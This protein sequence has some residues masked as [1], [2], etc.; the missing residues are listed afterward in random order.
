MY[1]LELKKGLQYLYIIHIVNCK[2]VLYIIYIY[3]TC[4]HLHVHCISVISV[5]VVFLLAYFFLFWQF[6]FALF[7]LQT[8]LR[9]AHTRGVTWFGS[10]G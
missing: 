4:T 3:S 7:I 5:L 8:L 2:S 9:C 6:V 10:L 1:N